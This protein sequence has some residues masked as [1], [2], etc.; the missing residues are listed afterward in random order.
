MLN[1]RAYEIRPEFWDKW[2]VT[3]ETSFDEVKR[4]IEF[5][6]SVDEL[7]MAVACIAYIKNAVDRSWLMDVADARSFDI[8]GVVI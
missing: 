2:A 1:I 7:D 4:L 8:G 3:E 6:N 5:A